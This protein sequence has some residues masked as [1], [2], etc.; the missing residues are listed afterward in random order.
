M[1]FTADV[2]YSLISTYL[3]AAAMFAKR[4]CEIEVTTSSQ[5][6][7]GDI[8]DEHHGYVLAAVMQAVAALE[9]EVY[10]VIV[11]GPGHH[12]GSN[13]IDIDSRE[14]LSGTLIGKNGRAKKPTL[15]VYSKVLRLLSKPPLSAAQRSAAALL[16]DLRNELTHYNSKWGV[17]M[18]AAFLRDWKDLILRAPGLSRQLRTGFRDAT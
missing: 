3:H 13:C 12:L 11:H 16:V 14:L 4:A 10:E 1:A 5:T 7:T 2:R 9:A 17:N 8:L 6:L 15:A 18:D